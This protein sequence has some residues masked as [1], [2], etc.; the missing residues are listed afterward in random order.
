ML[1]QDFKGISRFLEPWEEFERMRRVLSRFETPFATEFP[2][3]NVWVNE[4]N[5]VVTTEIPG[6]DLKST[7]ISITG[8]SLTLRGSRQPE[9]GQ[10]GDTYHRRE[11]WYGEFTKIIDLPFN[12]EVD[13]VKARFKK[14]IL[15]LELPRAEAEKPKKIVVKSE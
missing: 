15:Y 7:D 11:R 9:D 13:K 1:W 5:A 10:E 3:V 14:G 8:K 6:I 4:D 12:I 2:A